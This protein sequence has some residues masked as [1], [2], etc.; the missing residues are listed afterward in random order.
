[1]EDEKTPNPKGDE[2]YDMGFIDQLG[3]NWWLKNP[4]HN[5]ANSETSLGT[6]YE[7][8][9]PHAIVTRLSDIKSEPI[10]WLWPGRIALGKITIISGDPGLGKSLLSQTLAACVSKGYPWPV[11]GTSAPLGDSILLSAE[12]DAADTI[13]PRL[14]AAGANCER[15]HILKAIQQVNKEGVPTERM[16]SLVLDIEHLKEALS[17]LPDCKL[18]VIDPISAYLD[19][20]ESHNNSAMRGLLA[21]LS[22]IAALYGVAVVVI[23]HLNKNTGGSA[24]H[25]TTGSL[26][27]VAAARAAFLVIK[28]KNNS[29]R[30]LFIPSK[31]NLAKDTT[32]LAYTICESENGNP[33]IAWE[34]EPITIT[35]DEALAPF[36]SNEEKTNTDWAIDFLKDELADG[37]K[38]YKELIKA[39]KESGV[40]EKTLRTARERLHV[41]TKKQGFHDSERVWSLPEHEDAQEVEDAQSKAEGV[42]DDDGRVGSE[43]EIIL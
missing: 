30:R 26:A 8:I 4:H 3:P 17:Q 27:F 39:G 21:P 6:S 14:E 5:E 28:D 35:A 1:M 18:V 32:G 20:A 7:T 13:R 34:L 10:S 40:S 15:I 24:L 16:F 2:G 22:D 19:G 37:A 41:T 29:E 31:N 11:E 33:I 36:E 23:S 25:R 12:D 42:F 9:K 43:A 38:T